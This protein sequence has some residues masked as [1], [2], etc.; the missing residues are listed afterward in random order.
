MDF[1]LPVSLETYVNEINNTIVKYNMTRPLNVTQL[2]IN[3]DKTY[4]SL[5]DYY[6]SRF[7]VLDFIQETNQTHEFAIN[8]SVVGH[9]ISENPNITISFVGSRFNI[10]KYAIEGRIFGV[11][12]GISAVFI[13]YAWY[14][15]TRNFVT[16]V[17][18][19]QLSM[20]SIILNVGCDFGYSLLVL[21][22]GLAN[23]DFL[24]ECLVTFICL[25]IVYFTFQMRM[26]ALLLKSNGTFENGWETVHIK[27]FTQVTVLMSVSAFAVSL[28]FHFPM[29]TLPY[30]YS[31][32]IPQIYYSAKHISSKK[33]DK[34]FVI[35]ST[36]GRLIPLWYFTLYPSNI[37]GGTSLPICVTFTIY[38]V[39][40]AVIVLLQNKFGGA[41]FLPK[42]SRPKIFDYTSVHVEP[43]TECSICMTEIHEGDETMTTPCQHSFHKECLSRWMEEKL[44]C[45]M[46]RAQLP[47]NI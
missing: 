11:V 29:V 40:Q 32:F 23:Y 27:F 33:K 16:D 37:N 17:N 22:I 2:K 25:I 28:A 43:G 35:L 3:I 4:E 34:W 21:E 47:P 19:L 45:P 41:F 39:L 10:M 5:P 46:C 26:M 13:S 42:S 44:V 20:P 6:H 7:F 14:S 1:P 24:S 12:A 36:I 8:Q 9:I 15:L 18:L 30:I 38:S 31:Y